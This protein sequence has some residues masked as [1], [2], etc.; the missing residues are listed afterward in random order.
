[1]TSA[2]ADRA[3]L[4]LASTSRYRRDLLS[5]LTLDFALEA[6]GVD[7]SPHPGEM[8]AALTGRLAL[9]K[10]MS[11]AQRHPHAL[12]IG[13]DQTATIDGIAAIGKPGDH[14]GARAQLLAASGRTMHFHT[15]LATVRI[16][17][18]FRRQAT[19][20]TRV[21]FRTLDEQ[22]IERYL[23]IEQPYD[24]AGSAKAEGLGIAL[25]EAIE[26]DDPTALIGL[27][28]IALARM[29]R[30]AGLSPLAATASTP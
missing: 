8:P 29:L 30:D 11:V 6:P 19:V 18:G 25:L 7:E 15:A 10:A 22:E 20:E 26:G 24:C 4:I 13:S 23:R 17:D 16:A 5:R 2:P 1:M 27:P 14:D 21:R 3:R 9:E 28:L 12:V